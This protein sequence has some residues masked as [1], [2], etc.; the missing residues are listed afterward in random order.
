M[1]TI[2]SIT[3]ARSF[4]RPLSSFQARSITHP[5]VTQ[6]TALTINPVIQ[7]ACTDELLFILHWKEA[8]GP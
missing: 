5:D 1:R 3:P 7:W 4:P 6:I 2:S 8:L